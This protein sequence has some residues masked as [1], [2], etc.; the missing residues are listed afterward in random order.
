MMIANIRKTIKKRSS[1]FLLVFASQK[2]SRENLFSMVAFFFAFLYVLL[3]LLRRTTSPI[4]HPE[5][6]SVKHRRPKTEI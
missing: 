3:L 4:A 5:K 1:R 2:H 6:I